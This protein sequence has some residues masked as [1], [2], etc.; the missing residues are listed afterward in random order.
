VRP[1]VDL[2]RRLGLLQAQ[3]AHG[4]IRK[5]TLNYKGELAGKKTRLLT[6]AFTA[7]LLEYRL[8][9]GVNLVNAEILARERGIEI[10]ESSNP[11]KG[12]FAA[13]LHSEVET[14]QGTTVAAGTLFGDQY[15][16]LVQLGPFR[17]EGYLDG[18]LLVFTHRDVPGMIGFIGTIFG[19]HQVNIAQMTVGRQTQGGEAIGILNLDCQPPEAAVNAVKAHPHISNVNVVKLPPAGELPGWLG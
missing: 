14:E 8:S 5:A 7:G 1:F 13:L 15:V 4:A 11:K 16:R 17:M 9:A 3:L 12:D 2:A 10:S 6:A 18:V 19:T